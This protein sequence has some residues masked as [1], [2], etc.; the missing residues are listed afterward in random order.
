MAKKKPRVL[1][2]ATIS[3]VLT[4]CGMILLA[5]TILGWR[6]ISGY[7][8]VLIQGNEIPGSDLEPGSPEKFAFLSG[9]AGE[10][11]VVN[12]CGLPTAYAKTLPDEARIQGSCCQPMDLHRYQEQVEGLKQYADLAIMSNDPY[13]VP[14]SLVKRLL[15]Y[16]ETIQLSEEEQMVYDQAMEMTDDK[17]PCCCMC[18]RWY[19]YRGQA[20][21]LITQLDWPAEDIAALLNLEEGC[22]GPGHQHTEARAGAFEQPT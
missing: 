10:R 15:E 9:Q 17:G 19:A 11:S 22:G 13:D 20:K 16:D 12:Y 8:H 5:V 18:W 1:S 6:P 7:V 3:N 4:W 14:V 2:R 21:Y